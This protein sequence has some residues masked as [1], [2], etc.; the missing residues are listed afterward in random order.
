MANFLFTSIHR[1]GTHCCMNSL[2]NRLPPRS[3]TRNSI[4]RFHS[5]P[6]ANIKILYTLFQA[7]S[8]PYSSHH[9]FKTDRKKRVEKASTQFIVKQCELIYTQKQRYKLCKTWMTLHTFYTYERSSLNRDSL[10][11]PVTLR[12]AATMAVYSLSLASCFTGTS[13]TITALLSCLWCAN[14]PREAK[15][16]SIF[17]KNQLGKALSVD[18]TVLTKVLFSAI[19]EELQSLDCFLAELYK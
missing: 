13:K 7:H 6:S 17:Y 4:T 8:N 11:T 19:F 1:K 2:I 12:W 15:V 5:A 16:K 10:L 9:Y 3:R 14:L 18:C